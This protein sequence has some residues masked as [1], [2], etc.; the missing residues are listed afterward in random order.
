[1]VLRKS[2]P[3]L[4]C[5][6]E[7][8]VRKKPLQGNFLTVSRLEGQGHRSNLIISA[9]GTDL[10]SLTPEDKELS[11]WVPKNLSLDMLEV[12]R[13]EL[14]S[15]APT[16]ETLKIKSRSGSAHWNVITNSDGEAI[17]QT[18]NVYRRQGQMTPADQGELPSNCLDPTESSGINVDHSDRNRVKSNV[19]SDEGNGDADPAKTLGE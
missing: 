14:A 7:K 1:M 5:D 16:M 19:Y 15:N 6:W 13:L 17:G 11:L 18:R 9:A 4:V 3:G 12:R 2:W 10:G 8:T